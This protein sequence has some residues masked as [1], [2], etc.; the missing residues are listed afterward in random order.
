MIPLNIERE[1]IIKATREIDLNGI[2]P[3]RNSKKYFLIFEGKRYPPKYVLSLANRFANGEGLDSSEFSGGQETNN[4]LKRLGFDIVKISSSG[5]SVIPLSSQK[6]TFKANQKGHKETCPECKN[7]IERMLKK[8]Y[9]VVEINYKPKVSTNIKDYKNKSFYRELEEIISELQKYRGYEDFVRTPTLYRCDFFVPNP[10][11]IVEFD[12]RQHFTL[13]REISLQKYPEN[14]KLGFS[15]T[16]WIARCDKIKAK[17]NKPPFR[18]EQR[19]WYDTLRDFL[20][21]IKG[22]KPTVRLYS[23]EIQ[24]C[25]LNPENTEDIEKFSELIKNR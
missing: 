1:H 23:K 6:K 2:P 25:S 12:E 8:V 13:P 3:R 22:L 14:L 24:W 4:F 11:F 19:A 7:T 16:K 5:T 17:N 9:G 20:P 10:G 15:R 21:K 18:D